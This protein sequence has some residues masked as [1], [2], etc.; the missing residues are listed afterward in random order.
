MLKQQQAAISNPENSI[1]RLLVSGQVPAVK[2]GE[3]SECLAVLDIN[4]ISKGH[5][6]IIPKNPVQEQKDIPKSAFFLAEELSKK[7][8][9]HLKA[10]STKAEAEKKFGES[11]LHLI[12]IYDKELSVSSKRSKSTPEELQ[13]VK[14]SLETIKLDKK[15]EIIKQEKPKKEKPLKLSRKIP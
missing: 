9:E 2:V 1:F 14:K 15:P 7:M 8:M 5:C 6:M 12:P 13:E 3:N 10:K 11:I 4:P